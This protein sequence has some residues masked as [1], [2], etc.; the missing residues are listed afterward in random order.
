MSEDGSARS[1]PP[2]GGQDELG[3]VSHS[4]RM[5]ADMM[6]ILTNL[7]MQNQQLLQQHLQ[8]QQATRVFGSLVKHP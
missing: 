2:A 3:N 1:D 7:T 6:K 5:M 4:K 8:Q